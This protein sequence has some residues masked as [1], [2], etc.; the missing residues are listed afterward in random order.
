MRREARRLRRMGGEDAERAAAKLSLQAAEVKLGESIAKD[1]MT[2]RGTPEASAQ[3]RAQG[4]NIAKG[5]MGMPVSDTERAAADP[6]FKGI[7]SS[8]TGGAGT[9]QSTYG[10]QGDIKKR[11]DLANTL[12]QEA[13]AGGVDMGS[14][15]ER[16]KKLGVTGSQL[17][18]FFERE[19]LSTRQPT[20]MGSTAA[21]NV[22]LTEEEEKSGYTLVPKGG[23]APDPDSYELIGLRGSQ[24]LYAPVGEVYQTSTP[25]TAPVLGT[26]A[27]EQ[28]VG[29]NVMFPGA[30]TGSLADEAKTQYQ[31]QQQAMLAERAAKDAEIEE[32]NR[33]RMPSSPEYAK[34]FEAAQTEANWRA[35]RAADAKALARQKS[36]E[37][38]LARGET[39]ERNRNA[40]MLAYRNAAERLSPRDRQLL[41]FG[42]SPKTGMP[43]PSLSSP[44]AAEAYG[45][46]KPSASMPEKEV[47]SKTKAST[48]RLLRRMRQGR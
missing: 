13:G 14:A 29:R 19:K 45:S 34:R 42:I 23:S 39:A 2:T 24:R 12:R 33:A 17:K 22:K 43:M 7:L 3:L 10:A 31:E 32:R 38:A 20:Q 16:A 15:Q 21:T 35:I 4:V 1:Q 28:Q 37:D 36:T 8:G 26:E 9:Q 40:A 6:A 46:V 5:V 48:A 11:I 44:E 25:A 27:Y 41:G 18:S 30:S 47:R